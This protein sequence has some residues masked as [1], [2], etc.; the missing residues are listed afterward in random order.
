LEEL[1]PLI[2]RHARHLLSR[3][4]VVGVGLGYKE[5]SGRR[6]D[7]KAVVVLVS[8]KIHPS[9]LRRADM[10]PATLAATRT[11]VVEVGELHLLLP[12]PGEAS[13]ARLGES[14]RTVRVRP[15]CPGMSVGHYQV[16]AGTF[17]ALVR[18]AETGAPMLLSNNHVLANITDGRDGR[19]KPGDPVYQPGRYDGGSTGDTIA[20]LERFVPIIRDAADETCPIARTAERVGNYLLRVAFPAHR[21]KF[22]RRSGGRNLV[23]AAVATF[24]NPADAIADILGIG[25][26][27]G[28]C[29]AKPGLKI[30]KSGRT[31]G[32]TSGEVRLI[33]ASVRVGLGDV[34]SAVF[35]DQIVTTGI[36]QPGDSGSLVVSQ[37]DHEAVGLLSAG[38][39]Q[40][41]IVSRI[42]NV[43]K[44]LG[45]T[46]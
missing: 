6:T 25:P 17:G 7:T 46:L 18:D 42:E 2:D 35:T 20:H 9:R 12:F 41:S 19:A 32:T 38:S 45:V 31:S 37:D 24:V 28:I 26:V 39:A 4:N 33:G 36:A 44:L 10:V 40:A 23:D 43:L 27:Q 11:D 22:S 5:S 16:T 30:V 21:M 14:D 34:G 29:A 8:R 15:A 13:A 3:A 1:R